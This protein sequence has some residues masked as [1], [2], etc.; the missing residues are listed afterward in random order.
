MQVPPEDI[1][2]DI[3]KSGE[4]NFEEKSVTWTATVSASQE[5][6]AIDL[7]GY[8]FEDD[9]TNA[10]P[11]I[12]GTLQVN[13]VAQLPVVSPNAISYA[14]PA[15]SMSP[16]TF[17]YQT[18]IP[19][20]KYLTEGEQTVGNRAALNDPTDLELVFDD[21]TLTF[22]PGWIVK[23]AS[24]VNWAAPMTRPTAPSLG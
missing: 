5:G 16:V 1:V 2:Y 10:G 21:A 17:T 9:L 22:T 24:Q 4:I 6:A 14:L 23:R 12:P 15:P 20:S 11:F 8:V 19:D 3:Q 7:A 18:E 13:G